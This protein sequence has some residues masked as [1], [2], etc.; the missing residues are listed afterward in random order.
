MPLHPFVE[1][2]LEVMRASGWKG[3]ATAMPAEARQYLAARAAQAG[4]PPEIGTSTDAA[5]PT[6]TGLI[7]GRVLMPKDWKP[8]RLVVFYHGGGW[9]LGSINECEFIAR[10]MIDKTNCAAVLVE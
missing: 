7:K 5:I 6:R 1:K 2:M 8:T 4:P 3:T 9:V 10:F